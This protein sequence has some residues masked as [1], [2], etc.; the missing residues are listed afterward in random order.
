MS[1]FPPLPDSPLQQEE[2]REQLESRK[3]ELGAHSEAGAGSAS[4][5]FDSGLSTRPLAFSSQPGR[6]EG[7]RGAKALVINGS[8][9]QF[10]LHPALKSLFLD[11]A[12]RCVSVI[13]SRTTPLQKVLYIY[14]DVLHEHHSR[15][16]GKAMQTV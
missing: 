2:T 8:T 12:R 3:Q 11:V 5:S 13:C 9:L 4:S 6:W 15:E 7:G 1:A 10:A 16:Q 14:R